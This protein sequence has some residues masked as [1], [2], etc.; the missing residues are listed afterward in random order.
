MPAAPIL[1]PGVRLDVGSDEGRRAH[2]G[3]VLRVLLIVPQLLAR[4][5]HDLQGD[6]AKS[7]IVDIRLDMRSG[8]RKAH[9]AAIGR[10][11]R[12]QP[13][14]QPVRQAVMND[15][16]ATHKAVGLRIAS[17]LKSAARK[18]A[19]EMAAHLV[20]HLLHRLVFARQGHLLGEANIL[21]AAQRILKSLLRTGRSACGAPRRGRG[22]GTAARSVAR[23]E[24][25]SRAGGAGNLRN[26]GKPAP[27]LVA[28]GARLR[29]NVTQ[30]TAK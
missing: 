9:P 3:E 4:N 14:A 29:R 24:G 25:R 22:G 21:T 18:V 17:P 11:R 12:E 19:H 20:D 6:A 2:R 23:R 30:R 1:Q 10:G 13:L 27:P 7:D 5:A 15:E 16:L 28:G 26:I 8:T